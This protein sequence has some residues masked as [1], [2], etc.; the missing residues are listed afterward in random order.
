MVDSIEYILNELIRLIPYFY[1]IYFA[2]L[3][4]VLINTIYVYIHSKE[5]NITRAILIFGENILLSFAMMA[6]CI[7]NV[8]M[9]DTSKRFYEGFNKTNNILLIISM[10]SISLCLINLII[11]ICYKIVNRK[12][13]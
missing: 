10:T 3:G 4:S 1:F 12:K 9:L 5:K 8:L 11:I 6:G 13:I 2:I 7:I